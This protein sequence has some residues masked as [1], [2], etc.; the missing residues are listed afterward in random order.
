[1]PNALTGKQRSIAIDLYEKQHPFRKFT[2][3]SRYPKLRS[4]AQSKPGKET[5]N[6]QDS[7]IQTSKVSKT[8]GA[9]QCIYLRTSWDCEHS[10]QTRE[11]A[12][13]M[14]AWNQAMNKSAPRRLAT[15]LSGLP[16]V[17]VGRPAGLPSRHLG[18]GT[19]RPSPSGSLFG[20][21]ARYFLP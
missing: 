8:S 2:R 3:P 6:P 15:E 18:R 1:M 17:T 5:S 9:L 7:Q 14:D 19:A 10:Q 21:Y 11:M 20:N 16:P 12:S 13:F 4:T